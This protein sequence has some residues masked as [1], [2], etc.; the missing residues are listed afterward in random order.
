MLGLSMYKSDKHRVED[1]FIPFCLF[2]LIQQHKDDDA[3]DRV[4]YEDGLKKLGH[5]ID[6]NINSRSLV[7]RIEKL[8]DSLFNSFV[9]DKMPRRK[10]YMIFNRLACI[11]HD[12]NSIELSEDCI[13]LLNTMSEAFEENIHIEDIRK[14]DISAAKQVAKVLKKLQQQGYYL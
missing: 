9:A 4:A 11:L 6:S 3:K 10:A 2:S 5:D 13:K 12:N 1:A 8:R 14:Q 7:K